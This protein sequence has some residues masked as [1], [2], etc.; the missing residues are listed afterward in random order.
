QME[1]PGFVFRFL[2]RDHITILN[3]SKIQVAESVNP[4]S[5]RTFARVIP[6]TIKRTQTWI[7]LLLLLLLPPPMNPPTMRDP[8]PMPRISQACVIF[9]VCFCLFL[10]VCLFGCLFV[11]LFVVCLFVY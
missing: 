2:H 6:H 11:C 3:T 8:T 7:L 10:F 5:S 9:V 4:T 1:E